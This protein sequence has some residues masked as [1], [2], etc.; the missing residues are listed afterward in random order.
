MR[1]A[2]VLLAVPVLLA[3]CAHEVSRPPEVQQAWV[4]AVAGPA[5][6]VRALTTGASCPTL[7]WA[8]GTAAMSERSAPG[9][10][11]PPP[12]NKEAERKPSR[13]TLRACEAAWPTGQASVQLGGVTLSAPAAEVRRIVVVGDSGCRLKGSERAYQACNDAAEWPFGRVLDQALALR[14]DLVIHVGDYHYRES[15]CPEGMAG[16]AGSPW[17]YGDDAWQAD[18]FRPARVLLAAAPWVFVRGNHEACSRAGQ[19]WL[20]YLDAQP[21]PARACEADAAAIVNE[22]DFT[23]PF[24][25][26]L[27]PQRQLIVFDSSAV[28]SRTPPVGSAAWLRWREQLL[29]VAELARSQAQNLFVNHHPSLAFSPTPHGEPSAA[30]SGLTPLLRDTAPGRLYPGSVQ[31]TL[32]GHIHL[33]QL[34]GFESDHPATLVAGNGGSAEDAGR[35]DDAA[36]L[37]YELQPGARLKTMQ[38]RTALGL[39]LLTATPE[40]W[41]LQALDTQGQ[42]M[43]SCVLTGQK[44]SC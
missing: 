6:A 17:G 44:L 19:G 31:L 18:F 22:G 15:P 14:P 21:V 40:G 12:G 38:S 7:S 28:G 4:Q 35:V 3:G 42:P 32:H 10:E 16:C 24:T 34:L 5:W 33:L 2:F 11:P 9:D 1:A 29:R 25:V 41:R 36:A 30:R 37:G 43:L 39:T 8:G 27:S 20:R 13:F 26:P 23:A